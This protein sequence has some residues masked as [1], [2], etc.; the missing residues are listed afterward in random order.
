MDYYFL[1]DYLENNTTRRD[2]FDSKEIY[3]DYDIL[4]KK[5]LDYFNVDVDELI[6]IIKDYKSDELN[7]SKLKTNLD[8]LKYELSGDLII[9]D[10]K[11][12]ISFIESVSNKFIE[13][14]TN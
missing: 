1:E 4:N 6:S 13:D 12:F 9:L 10:E 8:C 14:M 3:K 7:Y 11:K 2:V 5:I